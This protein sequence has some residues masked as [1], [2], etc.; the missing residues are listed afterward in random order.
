M[1]RFQS[2]ENLTVPVIH[3]LIRPFGLCHEFLTVHTI[4]K[5]LMP[6]VV[7]I[8]AVIYGLAE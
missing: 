1:E 2:G 6:I 5:F 8:A 3:A 7:S 4:V